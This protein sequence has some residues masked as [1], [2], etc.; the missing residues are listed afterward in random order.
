M[1]KKI[2]YLVINNILF[3]KYKDQYKLF[4]KPKDAI[5][6]ANSVG[7]N[8]PMFDIDDIGIGILHTY[9]AGDVNVSIIALEVK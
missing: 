8:S 6:H 7:F 2:V 1:K 4:N 3:L 5:A 9:Q